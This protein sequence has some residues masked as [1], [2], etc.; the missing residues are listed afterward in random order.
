MRS[1]RLLDPELDL[2]ETFTRLLGVSVTG[3]EAIR[4]GRNSQVYRVRC[5]D[6]Q[7]YVAKCYLRHPREERRRLDVEFESLQFLWDA[8]IR[9]IP[10]PVAADRTEGVAVYE[11][12]DG[13]RIDATRVTHD[14]VD[15]AVEFLAALK[16]LRDHPASQRLPAASEACFSVAAIGETID[17]RL[18]RLSTTDV[19]GP[20]RVALEDFLRREFTPAFQRLMRWCAVSATQAGRSV[21]EEL[22][23]AHRTLSPS[24]F[25][26][27][28]ALRRQDGR[29][30]FVDFEHFGWDD[31]AKMIADFLL[32]PAMRLSEDL[33]R[34][35]VHRLLECFKEQAALG[36]RLRLV[37]PLFGLK[38][39]M[40]LLNEFVPQDRRRRDFATFPL[41]A[42]D[43]LQAEQLAKARQ[44][45][46][47]TLQTYDSF[48]Y[49]DQ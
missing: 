17:E 38:W 33:K 40:I 2:A 6:Q 29:I 46:E 10:R 5:S 32:H 15:M 25:G 43:E 20:L 28:N 44:K 9:A 48:P 1:S 14:E 24:D 37:Y 31:P 21:K 36:V 8:G 22:P 34:Q 4:D 11:S 41:R 7:V 23:P 49:A 26:F 27:H 3:L 18:R 35:F 13:E 30:M 47:D 12:I 19:E 45:L 16:R 39:C 42:P